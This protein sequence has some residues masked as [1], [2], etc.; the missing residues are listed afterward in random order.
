MAHLG[1]ATLD[2]AGASLAE[3]L[4]RARMSLQLGHFFLDLDRPS[5]RS[6]EIASRE[7]EFP[8]PGGFVQ[9]T[10]NRLRSFMASDRDT[11]QSHLE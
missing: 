9:Y 8:C 3:A 1:L 5:C 7:Q 2:F 10:P 11:G 6:P 4:L